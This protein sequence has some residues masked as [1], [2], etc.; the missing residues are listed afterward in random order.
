M[1]NILIATNHILF[2]EFIT[3]LV[4][5]QLKDCRIDVT[6][7]GEEVL[8]K[9]KRV[10]YDLCILD[11]KLDGTSGTELVMLI[12]EYCPNV[13]LL[14]LSNETDVNYITNLFSI[15]VEGFLDH[16]ATKEEFVEALNK[17]L[18][19]GRYISSGFAESIIYNKLNGSK[20]AK[21]DGLSSR[22][23]QVMIMLAKGRSIKE[24][25]EKVFLS[26]KTISTYK[27]RIFQKMDFN[28]ISQL[29]R[30]VLDEKLIE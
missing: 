1:Q 28:N 23:M 22:E 18:A 3:R 2:G 29:I 6:E 8:H 11:L 24:I 7:N 26:D 20:E 4:A 25:S 9:L 15:G 5:E 12:K 21:H 17:M 13:K 14:L 16:T 27:A 30:Y 10:Q 19:K